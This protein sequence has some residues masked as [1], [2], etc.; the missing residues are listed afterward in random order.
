MTAT[1]KTRNSFPLNGL[2]M[3]VV[4]DFLIFNDFF[5]C[6]PDDKDKDIDDFIHNDAER[7]YR[8]KVAVTYGLFKATHKIRWPLGFATLQNDTI[9]IRP[10]EYNIYP[11]MPAV[12]IGRFG[13]RREI[14]RKR[15]GTTFMAM[16][17]QFMVCDNRTGCRFLTLNTYPALFKFYDKNNFIVL[18]GM[19]AAP[20]PD[21]QLSMYLDLMAKSIHR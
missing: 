12:K 15:F 11:N 21:E 9:A 14:Q 20:D 13:I 5:C 6:G 10:E 1:P 3:E 4:E 2:I 18:N 8:D 7:H 17:R 19:P 16:I